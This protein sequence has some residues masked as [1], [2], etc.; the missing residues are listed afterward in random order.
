MLSRH[1]PP[2]FDSLEPAVAPGAPAHL[3]STRTALAAGLL[4]MADAAAAAAAASVGGTTTATATVVTVAATT[5]G[6]SPKERDEGGG[7]EQDDDTPRSSNSSGEGVH[8]SGSPKGVAE[9][10]S[11]P[12]G[13]ARGQRVDG[14]AS[15]GTSREKSSSS[16]ETAVKSKRGHSGEVEGLQGIVD[17]LTGTNTAAA[18]GASAGKDVAPDA[19]SNPM[20]CPMNDES[21]CAQSIKHMSVTQIKDHW[22]SFLQ[23]I[24]S[25][26][27][28]APKAELEDQG[29]PLAHPGGSMPA[30][31]AESCEDSCKSACSEGTA[32]AAGAGTATGGLLGRSVSA[33]GGRPPGMRCPTNRKLDALVRKYLYLCKFVGLFNPGALYQLHAIDL[34][35]GSSGQVP[36]G[37]HWR[38]VVGYLELTSE[39]VSLALCTIFPYNFVTYSSNGLVRPEV[40]L[41]C[42]WKQLRQD[43]S[44]VILRSSGTCFMTYFEGTVLVG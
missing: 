8:S 3:I 35:N 31:S 39:Q 33:G 27:L 26:L 19:C 44:P 24:S 14:E 23:D 6:T 4:P 21:C 2:S 32:P 36:D 43:G 22:K 18:A 41:V 42:T 28:I 9:G 13:V 38:K 15:A 20:G 25:L 34:E 30:L 40:L 29:C 12:G 17:A 11:G 10:F 7:V 5:V 16:C 1:G 37:D